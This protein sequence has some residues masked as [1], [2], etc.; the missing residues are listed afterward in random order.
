MAKISSFISFIFGISRHKKLIVFIFLIIG[1]TIVFYL[2]KINYL[3]PENITTLLKLHPF[4]SPFLFIL[5]YALMI[6]FLFPT[7][8]MNLA[9]GFLFGW[10]WGGIITILGASLGASASFIIARYLA[11]DYLNK[12]FKGK[13]F[14]SLQEEIQKKNWKVVA[15]TRINPI[16]PSGLLNYIFGLTT[17]PFNNYFWATIL[18]VLPPVF[19]FSF[20][21]DSIGGFVLK[22]GSYN[23]VRNIFIISFIATSLVILQFIAKKY[24]VFYRRTNT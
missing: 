23:L 8:P 17:I 12:K 10:F 15:F 3:T 20:I 22:G 16:F 5:F 2:R 13:F 7:L 11:S 14:L 18:F 4:L 9:A 21:G 19:L 1:L 6:I 24:K